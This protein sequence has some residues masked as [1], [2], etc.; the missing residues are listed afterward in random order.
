[1]RRPLA[2]IGPGLLVA[3]TGVG[4]GDLASAGF[5][6]SKLGYAILWAV[7]LGAFLKFMLTEGL[8]RWQIAT[9]STLLEGIC[10]RLG[11]VARLVFILY[12]LPWTFFVGAALISACGVATHAMLPFPIALGGWLDTPA[13]SGKFVYGLAHSL[14]A[15]LLVVLG[16][17]RL[18]EKVMAGA[19]A[20]MFAAVVI[21]AALLAPEWPS[22]LRGLFVPTIP[23]DHPEALDWTVGLMGGV[24]GTLTILAYSYWMR[25]RGRERAEHLR[26][27]RI[28]LAVGYLFTALFGVAMV[29]IARGITLDARGAGLIVQLAERLDDALGPAGRWLFLVGAW[30]AIASSLLGV[31]QSVPYI[32]ADFWRLSTNATGPVSDRSTPYRVYLAVLALVPLLGVLRSFQQA[33]KAYVIFGAFFVP[34]LAIVLLVLNGRSAWVGAM[35]N[36]PATTAVLVVVLALAAAGAWV[37]IAGRI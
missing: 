22:V 3:A 27:C 5:A 18:F 10:L 30:A 23:H 24:G 16:G 9:G 37:E 17:Y 28:D 34:L 15:V 8:A 2:I 13:Q 26:T 35:R 32:F 6:G 11:P 7:L 21:T 20:I 14:V 4:A 19:V 25:E 31:W 36:R 33:Q 29:I 12:L 1:M